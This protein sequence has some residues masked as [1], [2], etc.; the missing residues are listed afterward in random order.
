MGLYGERTGAMHVVCNDKD[1]ADRCMSQIKQIIRANYSSPP[2]HGAR[3]AAKVLMK[4]ENRQQWLK[5]LQAVTDRMNTMRT[6]LKAAL[7]K[8]GTK[9]NWDHVT[10]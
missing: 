1:T 6:A 10:K 7:V 3:I 5:E 9:G 2:V 8:N 4:P